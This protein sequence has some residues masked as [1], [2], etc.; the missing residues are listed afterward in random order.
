MEAR[1]HPIVEL[2]DFEHVLRQGA[3]GTYGE[4][5]ESM[6]E[7]I[8]QT[9]KIRRSIQTFKYE[10]L[11]PYLANALLFR[12]AI[13]NTSLTDTSKK[14]SY[15]VQCVGANANFRE[16]GVGR[17]RTILAKAVLLK[18]M[19]SVEALLK[20]GADPD[21]E[22][23]DFAERTLAFA[24]RMG[25]VQLFEL[26]NK[27]GAMLYTADFFGKTPFLIACSYSQVEVVQFL[28]KDVDI[29]HRDRFGMNALHHAMRTTTAGSNSVVQLLLASGISPYARCY[30]PCNFNYGRC[31]DGFTPLQLLMDSKKGIIKHSKGTDVMN[32]IDSNVKAVEDRI[33]AEVVDWRMALMIIC[34]SKDPLPKK[35][36]SCDISDISGEPGL[37]KMILEYTLEEY[38]HDAPHAPSIARRNYEYNRIEEF[39]EHYPIDNCSPVHKY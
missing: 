3:S 35:S 26:Y 14:I 38:D 23:Y 27:H 20:N 11:S 24:A 6:D 32:I 21:A 1:K 18:R 15:L 7:Y 25:M 22:E 17:G 36:E 37:I 33:H 8:E 16:A 19:D 2:V 4:M 13:L 5:V 10:R 9:R 28:I 34:S 31:G 30:A 12:V 29:S 39:R